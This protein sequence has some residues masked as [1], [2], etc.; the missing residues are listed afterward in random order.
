MD[1]VNT[2]KRIFS[3]TADPAQ[4]KRP[5]IGQAAGVTFYPD[6]VIIRTED[7]TDGPWIVSAKLTILPVDTS[8]VILGQ[9][10]RKHFVLTEHKKYEA[11]SKDVWNEYK[12]AA[13]FKTNKE[14]Y[15]DARL[16]MCSQSK[17]EITLTPTENTYNTGYLPI[18]N[19]SINLPLTVSDENLGIELEKARDISTG[20]CS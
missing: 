3:R 17:T 9:T 18:K 1:L 12:K 2:I 20:Y 14:T 19:T 11:K 8:P 7:S 10:L 16:I 15:K 13:G 5:D 6:K 4:K